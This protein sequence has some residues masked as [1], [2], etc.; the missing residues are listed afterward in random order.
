[1]PGVHGLDGKHHPARVFHFLL[2]GVLQEGNSEACADVQQPFPVRLVRGDPRGVLEV[3][4]GI[5]QVE[6]TLPAGVFQGVEVH[7]VPLQGD[8]GNV[9]A[10]VAEKGEDVAV[11]G[12]F[13][14]HC[15]AGFRRHA[16][17]HVEGC[18]APLVM[19]ISSAVTEM[20]WVPMRAA[21]ASRRP[22]WPRGSPYPSREVPSSRK[23]LPRQV[24]KCSIGKRR[25]SIR[26]YSK[27]IQPRG[28]EGLR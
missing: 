23:A 22:S 18:W 15:P 16:E 26:K 5:D 24:R 4:H 11:G 2:E 27:E 19:R 12:G 21:I 7:A 6:G 13:D 9:Q 14:G 8:F 1:M 25:G 3:R 28:G 20:P 17:H 10:V